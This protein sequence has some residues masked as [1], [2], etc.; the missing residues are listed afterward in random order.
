MPTLSDLENIVDKDLQKL[1]A[2]YEKDV[3]K[4]LK[5]TLDK[6]RAEMSR[7]YEKWA[8]GG[9]LTKVEMTNYNKYQTMEKHIIDLLDPAIKA[10]LKSIKALPPEAY[11]AAF[12]EYAWAMDEGAGVALDWG[13]ADEEAIRKLY[14]MSN[15]KNLEW[16]E[17]LK[18][19]PITAKKMVRAAL[20][21]GLAEGKGYMAMIADLKNAL[22]KYAWQ[23]LRILRTEG[24]RMFS[25]AQYD[26]YQEAR[27]LGIEGEDMWNATLDGRTR[28]S[29]GH[30]DGKKREKDGYFYINGHKALYPLDPN[31]PPEEQ[32]NCR[33][34][35]TFEIEGYAPQVRR[36]REQGIL[37]YQT[38]NQWVAE[39]H[40]DWMKK[41]KGKK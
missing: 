26:R 24:Q 40:P 21:K 27:D 36:S 35:L 19:L 30:A 41:W 32:I 10:S 1:L 6:M 38:Y 29:H 34:R 13:L 9:V 20:L 15:P 37:P 31:L 17:A 28:E 23:V 8:K 33:C 39:Y 3:E 14:D 16:I 11:K 18:T 22:E 2:S 5:E 25:K 12:F 7:I 4:V